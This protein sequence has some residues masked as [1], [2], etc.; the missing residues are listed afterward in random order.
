M[1][2]TTRQLEWIVRGFSSHR[3]IQILQL[4]EAHRQLDLM[5]IARACGTTFR[6]ASEHTRRLSVAGLIYKRPKGRSVLHLL[7]SRGVHVLEFLR[8]VR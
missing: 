6:N 5:A 8:T 3:R 2:K 1:P 4:L 7:S